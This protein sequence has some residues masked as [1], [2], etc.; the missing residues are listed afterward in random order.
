MSAGISAFTLRSRSMGPLREEVAHR[1]CFPCPVWDATGNYWQLQIRFRGVVMSEI[2]M[3]SERIVWGWEG[4]S[5]ELDTDWYGHG[6]TVLLLPAL[7][8]I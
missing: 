7:S 2:S 8:S 4:A 1:P 3:Q 6:P 5:I